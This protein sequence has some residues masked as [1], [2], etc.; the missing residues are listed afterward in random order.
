MNLSP[1]AQVAW[2][3]AAME[4]AAARASEI[5]PDHFLAGL[6]KL[7]QV[8]GDLAPKLAQAVGVTPKLLEP[9]FT[10]V[11]GVLREAGVDPDMFRR[12]LRGRLGS[13]PHEHPPGQQGHR[14]ATSR[15]RF[16]RAAALA[17]EMN[18][19]TVTTGHLFLALLEMEESPGCRL[20]IEK[21]ANLDRL[22]Q[23]ARAR[24]EALPR[25]SGGGEVVTQ[26]GGTPFL[27]RYGRDL[28]ALAKEGKLGPVIGRRKEIL[29]V[30][31]TL[32]RAS[33]NNPVLV[34]EAGVGKTAIAEAI[35]Q[36]AVQRKDAV[37]VC[38]RLV[39][40]SLGALVAG[41][42]YRGQFEERITEIIEECRTH[43]EV[44][45][46]L[47][48]LHTVVGAGKGEGGP[49]AANLLKPALARGEIRCMGATTVTEYRRHIESDAALERRFE[50]VLVAEPSRE[51][52]LEILK[53]LR[54][55]WEAHHGVRIPD[56]ALDCAVDLAVRFDGDH[57]LPDKAI[58]LV[59]RAAAQVKVPVLSLGP[60]Q[61]EAA[62][63]AGAPA[64]AGSGE[65]TERDIAKVLAAKLGV[66]AEVIA[67]HLPGAFRTRLLELEGFLKS[68][69]IGQD[70][71][72][73]RVCQRL[74]LAHAGLGQRRGPLAVFLFLGPTGVGKTE[75]VRCLAEYLFG[76]ER[77]LIRL[78]MSEY[79]EEH[80]V[81]RLIGAPPGYVGH[82]QEGQLTGRLRSRPYAVVLL[83]EVEK[84]HPRV[85][86][87]F[88]QVFD[89]G[90][91]TDGRGRTADARHAIFVLTSNIPT[92]RQV[93]FQFNDT[94]ASKTAVLEE[95]RRR[96]RPE[97]VNRLDDQIVF[98]P[99]SEPDVRRV[100]DRM[101]VELCAAFAERHQKALA[102]TDAARALVAA[103]GYSR[104]FGVRQLRRTLEAMVEAPLSRLVLDPAFAT[105]PGVKVD[106][107]DGAIRLTPLGEG[108]V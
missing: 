86:D 73:D 53:G 62:A 10:L 12:E 93:G 58:D 7:G 1:I 59:D 3:L 48:E 96:F 39:E 23:L 61:V 87:L 106:V 13:G 19:E 33:K 45:L 55:R 74:L 46:F 82:E 83:D 41:T 84:A 6:T 64:A 35:A 32:S 4:T 92:D 80:N 63:A 26:A 30:V 44:I 60:G 94:A 20:L 15:Q 25:P 89:D 76:S 81:A 21:G 38:K 70:E 43:P 2:Q 57:Q 14:S 42:T 56:T 36:R 49:D 101:V 100:L 71:A 40:L 47:D 50:K 105:W 88:L 108:T 78:D 8:V 54:S 79:A 85:F 72:V 97:F 37:L 28:T 77:E 22:T 98:R 104:E 67:G 5:E 107:E 24:T 29:Q 68:R 9:E 16:E 102:L 90:R 34:G 18:I 91:L 27:D 52:S 69:V 31:Q 11:A 17:R 103:R 66:P 65:V 99:L 51:E 75:L 95:V